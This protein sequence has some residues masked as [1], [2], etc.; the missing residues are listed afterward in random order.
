M[1]AVKIYMMFNQF[2]PQK[3]PYL[4]ILNVENDEVNKHYSDIKSHNDPQS[5][6][7]NKKLSKLSTWNPAS[8]C[9]HVC[10]IKGFNFCIGKILFIDLSILLIRFVKFSKTIKKKLNICK[11]TN[12][13]CLK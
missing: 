12:K 5:Y 1:R 13:R 10:L 9:V 4:R 7:L 3:S 8:D 2:F 6:V 11:K